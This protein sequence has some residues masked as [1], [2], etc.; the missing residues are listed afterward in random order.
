MNITQKTNRTYINI[1]KRYNNLALNNNWINPDGSIWP[2]SVNHLLNYISFIHK[3]INPQ[4]LLSYLSA[5][6]D[7]HASIGLEWNHIRFDPLIIRALK[8]IKRNYL[9]QPTKKAELISRLHLQQL[10][11]TLSYNIYDNLLFLAIAFSSFYGLARLGEL[12]QSN[13]SSAVNTLYIDNITIHTDSNPPCILIYLPIAKTRNS[14][15]PDVLI[16][17]KSFDELCPFRILLLYLKARLSLNLTHDPKYLFCHAD[18]SLA[19]KQWFLNKLN[20]ISMHHL[21]GHGFRA[22]GTTELICRG[23]PPYIVQMIG[24]WSSDA[25]EEYIRRHPLVMN[26]YLAFSYNYSP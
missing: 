17:H 9:H 11:N 14:A 7:K 3:S 1:A 5:L 16:I 12:I 8:L 15:F 13:S 23:L 22:G 6:A 2:I 4:T 25:F 20:A 18:G 10:S 19:T 24:R 26:A 21:T